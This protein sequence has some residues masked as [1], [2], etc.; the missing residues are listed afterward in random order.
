MLYVLYLGLMVFCQL[1]GLLERLE[2]T[3]QVVRAREELARRRLLYTKLASVQ[4]R[5][6]NSSTSFSHKYLGTYLPTYAFKLSFQCAL[7][8]WISRYPDALFNKFFFGFIALLFRSVF[9]IRIWFLEFQIWEA[10][11][12]SVYRISYEFSTD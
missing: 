9:E 3:E 8:L 11:Y 4:V 1:A 5:Y 2:K 7:R 12:G 10:C 6:N